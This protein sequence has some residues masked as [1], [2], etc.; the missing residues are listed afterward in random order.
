VTSKPSIAPT[1]DS[2]KVTVNNLKPGQKI[3]VTVKIKVK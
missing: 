3:K 2:S 1:I